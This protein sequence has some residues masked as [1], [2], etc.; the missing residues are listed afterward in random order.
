G[1]GLRGALLRVRRAGAQVALTGFGERAAALV[2]LR[3]AP[4]DLV[5]FSPKVSAEAVRD[6]RGEA[7]VAALVG[8]TRALGL[9]SAASGVE[10]AEQLHALARAGCELAH[11]PLWGP[12][13]GLAEL[14]RRSSSARWA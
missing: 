12:P 10:S 6:R 2:E 4:L 1:S 9:R 5:L 3:D 7:V 8:L 13:A 14:S 11:G